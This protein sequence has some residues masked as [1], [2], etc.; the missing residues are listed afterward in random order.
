MGIVDEADSCSVVGTGASC[1]YPLLGAKLNGWQ[2]LATEIDEEAI[3]FACE[4]VSRNGL[5]DK[6]TGMVFTRVYRLTVT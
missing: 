4:N 6:I 3:R 5:S 1:I 2:F